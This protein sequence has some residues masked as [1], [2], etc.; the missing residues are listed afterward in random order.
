M[1]RIRWYDHITINIYWLGLNMASGSLTP[2]I[3]PF[4]VQTF[5]GEATKNT[6]LG[7]LRSA[8]LIVAILV[9]PAAGLLSDRSTSR[10]GRRRPFI[11]VGT[12][13]D[14]LF[15]VCIG[16]SGNYWMLFASVLLLQFSSNVA[17]GALQ[18]LIPDLVPEDQRGRSSGVKAIMELLPVVLTA[19]TVAKLVGAGQV[20]MAL[21][22]VIGSLLVT[23]L[24]TVLAVH[25]EPL[26]EPVEKPL[27]PLLARVAMLT[28]IF[29]VV[30]TVFG[31]MVG[32]VGRLLSGRGVV[33]LVAVAVAGL[34]AMAGAIVFGVWGSA[35]VGIGE[36]AQRYP[37]FVWWVINRLLYLAAVGSIQS[38]A[39]YYI[40]HTLGLTKEQAA[41]MTGSL[42]MIVGI[43][44]LL[45]A[46]PSGYLADKFGRKRWVAL[47]GVVAAAGTALLL[48][49]T[50]TTM[51]MVSGCIIGLSAG[52]FM[53]TNWALGTD[54]VP[55][56]EAGRYLGISN[57]AGAGAG[58]VGAGIG[59]PMADFFNSYRPG[60]GYLVVFAIYGAIFLLSSLVLVKVREPAIGRAA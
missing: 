38:F 9:Q 41:D 13:L 34:V 15:L 29:V 46:L 19:F 5:V 25:E 7:A 42:M 53:T 36:G 55:S 47:T 20:W 2:I 22:V 48:V 23:M 60:L 54:L 27:R 52:A 44:T 37:S 45:S 16:F 6:A 24:I 58:V 21:L 59:G 31:G 18:G 35:Q 12:M 43:F 57:L 50:S 8:G 30:T 40:Q 26:R 17:H 14:I 51:V 1:K 28:L 33:Q 49:S 32:F 56:E 4:L 10:W 39:Q 3:L 11:F